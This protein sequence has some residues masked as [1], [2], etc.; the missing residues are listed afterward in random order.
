M[1]TASQVLSA[2][3]ARYLPGKCYAAWLYGRG[4][5]RAELTGCDRWVIQSAFRPATKGLH[6]PSGGTSVSRPASAPEWGLWQN[7]M[8]KAVIRSLIAGFSS[9]VIF[10]GCA[11]RQVEPMDLPVEPFAGHVVT[12]PEGTWFTPCGSDPSTRWWVTYVD[13]AVAQAADA[14]TAGLLG[15]KQRTFVRWRASRTDERLVGPGGPALLVRDIFEV[16]PPSPTDC[17]D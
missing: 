10:A 7:P 1:R 12:T 17:G 4:A 13:R 8:V 14:K 6:C 16:R 5:K 2:Q 9:I 11:T 15:E 3:R